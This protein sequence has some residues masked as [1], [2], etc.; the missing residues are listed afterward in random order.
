[1]A[2]GATK[3]VR[4]VV[5]R[6]DGSRFAAARLGVHQ[7]TVCACASGRNRSKPLSGCGARYVRQEAIVLGMLKEAAI[8]AK[9]I[10]LTEGQRGT[11]LTEPT[12]WRLT[13]S[14]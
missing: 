10:E 8:L 2:A 9:Y 1:M 13:L 14:N 6:L 12:D 3:A 4:A 7:S 5:R 11:L